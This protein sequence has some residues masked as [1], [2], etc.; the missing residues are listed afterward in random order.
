MRNFHKRLYSKLSWMTQVESDDTIIFPH[1]ITRD[2]TKRWRDVFSLPTFSHNIELTLNEEN[3]AYR[4]TGNT[5]KL[6]KGQMHGILE[7]LAAKM[8][9]YKAYPKDQEVSVVAET[10]VT[11]IRDLKFQVHRQ[12][13][14][15][16]KIVSN[17]KRLHNVESSRNL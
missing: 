16:G 12:D 14:M 4:R 9:T 3:L 6:T 17:L 5:L 10:L 13:I 2:R 1:A 7:A 8:H 11:A 15:A